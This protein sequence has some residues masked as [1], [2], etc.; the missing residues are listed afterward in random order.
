M[1]ILSV[2]SKATDSSRAGIKV[3][4]LDC[5]IVLKQS[6][7]PAQFIAYRSFPTSTNSPSVR[8]KRSKS[9]PPPPGRTPGKS[10]LSCALF[11]SAMFTERK[12]NFST[13]VSMSL[14]LPSN[15]EK[16]FFA[17][18]LSLSLLNLV[19][20]T[21][22]ATL[23]VLGCLLVGFP[24]LVSLR[25]KLSSFTFK[26]EL[27]R[28]IRGKPRLFLDRLYSIFEFPECHPQS[29]TLIFSPAIEL[30]QFQLKKGTVA[31]REPLDDFVRLRFSLLFCQRCCI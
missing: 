1:R 26:P 22:L 29:V 25:L 6:D 7:F 12:S 8:F 28:Q 5:W 27:F 20:K 17:E 30:V 2:E 4:T 21:V 13:V 31:I 24:C 23:D 19:H 18:C 3:A 10:S 15:C 9:I 16:F 11:S 14:H